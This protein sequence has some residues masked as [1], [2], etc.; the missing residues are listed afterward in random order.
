MKILRHK[1]IIKIFFKEKK[2]K[3]KEIRNKKKIKQDKQKKKR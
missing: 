1:K 3:V 2:D